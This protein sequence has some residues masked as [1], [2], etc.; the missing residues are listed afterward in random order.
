M[1][2]FGDYTATFIS[3]WL[4]KTLRLYKC[5]VVTGD[6]VTMMMECMNIIKKV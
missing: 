3:E 5:G 2:R 4:S 1:G 6:D